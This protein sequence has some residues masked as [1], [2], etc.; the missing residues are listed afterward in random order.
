ML[1]FYNSTGRSN[2]NMLIQRAGS[3]YY[4]SSMKSSNTSSN[5]FWR[6]HFNSDN[7]INYAQAARELSDYL[8]VLFLDGYN[9]I[10]IPSRGAWPIYQ[11]ARTAWHLK[12]RTVISSPFP[13][14]TILP[15]SADPTASNQTTLA[16]RKYWSRV[17]AA[18]TRREEDN[19]YLLAYKGIIDHLSGRQWTD[20]LS[21]NTPNEKFIFIDTVVSGR[22]IQE[23]TSCFEELGLSDYYLILIIDSNGESIDRKYKSSI[24]KLKS[25]GRCVEIFIKDLFT[26]DRGP[27]VSGIWSTVYPQF[28]ERFQADFGW[29]SYGAGS[30]YFRIRNYETSTIGNPEHNLPFTKFYADLSVSLY[31]ALS[32]L[33]KIDKL[34]GYSSIAPTEKLD[35]LNLS[36]EEIAIWDAMELNLSHHVDLSLEDYSDPNQLSPIDRKTTQLLATPR[37]HSIHPSA[38]VSTTG[39]HLIRVEFDQTYLNKKMSEINRDIRSSKNPFL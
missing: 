7:I 23:I 2:Q 8:Q 35:K 22:A 39:S 15:F 37:V 1:A 25:N 31:I 19:P 34:R 21:K 5:S 6:D 36:Q 4:S 38:R 29:D 30:F 16:I 11:A 13:N 18:I 24:E 14:P 32:G 12:Q 26:E 28:L 33:E 27:A 9:S 17:L 20:I 3:D 10:I